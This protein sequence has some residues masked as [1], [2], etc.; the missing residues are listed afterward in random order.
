MLAPVLLL[1]AH[2][3]AS[4]PRSWY[5]ARFRTL[6]LT[7]LPRDPPLSL[8]QKTYWRRAKW[9]N[10]GRQANHLGRMVTINRVIYRCSPPTALVKHLTEAVDLTC[11]PP[12]TWF[13]RR[14]HL[15]CDRLS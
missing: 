9:L 13:N 12:L 6:I 10:R 1:C 8:L 15:L 4:L 5:H 7:R 3:L 11:P 14:G 2:S